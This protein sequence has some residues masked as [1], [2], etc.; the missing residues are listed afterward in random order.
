MRTAERLLSAHSDRLL[1]VSDDQDSLSDL[2]V[3]DATGVW[4]HGDNLLRGWLGELADGLKHQAAT[5]AKLDGKALSAV[6]LRLRRLSEPASLAPVREQAVAAWR[7]LITRGELA[8]DAVTI[9]RED[10][11]NA[12]MRYL[13]T[14]SGVVDLHAGRLLSPSAGRK[15]L[16]TWQTPVAFDP[17]ATHPAVDRLFAHLDPEA[18]GWWWRVLGFH[19]MG[20]PSR[21]F[22]VAV[23]PPSGGKTTLANAIAESLGPY[24]SRPADDA[25]ESRP[26]GSAGLSPELE[27]FVSP[28]RW[29]I[30]DEAPRMKIA[31][32]LLKR[33]SGD[34]PQTFRRLH[35][36][37]RTVPATAT[38]LVICNPGS[39]PRLRLQDE[40]MADRLRELPYPAVPAAERDPQFKDIVKTDDFRRA[41]L[42]RMVA[43]AAAETPREPPDDVPV[44][45]TATDERVREDVGELGSFAC[46]I[47]RG[48]GALT[49]ADL[50]AAWCEHNEE[51]ADAKEAGG[52]G[53]RRLS[54]AL[55]DHVPGLSTPKQI[56]VDGKKARGW[57]GWC[58]LTLAY[59]AEAP[60][61]RI[62]AEA[63]SVYGL[64]LTVD[65]LTA[66]E[67]ADFDLLVPKVRALFD[68]T[69]AQRPKA[70]NGLPLDSSGQP[71]EPADP[72]AVAAI[73]VRKRSMLRSRG[74]DPDGHPLGSSIES[75]SQLRSLITMMQAGDDNRRRG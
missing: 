23:G 24:A 57:R 69:L 72:E 73:E 33:L 1:V 55:R 62:I 10:E 59:E 63:P 53:K 31:A 12:N 17:A 74:I 27:A 16:V 34:A 75:T 49:V 68:W 28:R 51:L 38:V 47:V 40:A 20:A 2:Y 64:T 45:R 25:L 9:C 44:V 65:D 5:V 42:A 13:G 43:A 48:A 6:L 61:K 15:A 37:L 29:A 14:M 8:A 39:V 46:R 35:E 18:V 30:I 3:L 54:T 52:I 19:L 70:P 58:L 11:L 21:R 60:A 32:P 4:T 26:G 41:F 56:T 71:Y 67:R 36:H 7:R 66:D 22:Y 50:W